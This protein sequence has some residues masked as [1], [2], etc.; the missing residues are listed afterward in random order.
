MLMSLKISHSLAKY[1]E[2]IKML[3]CIYVIKNIRVLYSLCYIFHF[4]NVILGLHCIK[5]DVTL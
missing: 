5:Y 1:K 4:N 2:N 3:K